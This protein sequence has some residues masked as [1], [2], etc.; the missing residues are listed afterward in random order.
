MLIQ[1]LRLKRGWSQ[2]QLAQASGLSA[3]TIQRI[4]AGDPASVE[5]LKSLAAVFEIDFSTLNPEQTMTTSTDTTAEK[6]EREAFKYVCRLRGFYMHPLC[7][8]L[9][10]A[11]TAGGQPDR[12]SAP[13]VGIVD[14][15]RLGTGHFA[16]RI[17]RLSAE[18]APRASMGARASGKA[19]GTSALAAL[20]RP[21]GPA[22]NWDRIKRRR[23]RG[24]SGAA[25]HAQTTRR[26]Q[27][28]V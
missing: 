12:I 8:R 1:K 7:V 6:Q 9:H 28:K 16:A 19:P 3:R 26:T 5:T 14:D 20:D 18:L 27:C 13:T 4:E 17:A 23:G 10:G 15:G 21:R 25:G 2:Q 11:R 22:A 24:T